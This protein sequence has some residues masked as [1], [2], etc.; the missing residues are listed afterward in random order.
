MR[1]GL[2]PADGAAGPG[3][4]IVLSD[5]PRRDSVLLPVPDLE[6]SPQD[7]E[8]IRWYLEDYR[9]F[10]S[11]PAPV[12]AARC[13]QRL[14]TL[15]EALFQAL[16]D[17]SED[18]RALWRRAGEQ[19]GDLR[20]EV[21]SDLNDVVAVPFELLRIPGG[22]ALS[23]AA[24]SFTHVLPSGQDAR[25]DSTPNHRGAIRIL[26]VICRPFSDRDVPFRSVAH[27]LLRSTERRADVRIQVLRPPTY[28]QLERTLLA[29]RKRG[30]PFH[31]VHFDG[32]G[33]FGA[34][35]A[36]PAQPAQGM[37]LFEDPGS[38]PSVRL[39]SGGQLGALLTRAGVSALVLNACRSDR[40]DPNTP[41]SPAHVAD[42]ESAPRQPPG[43]GSLARNALRSGLGT[44]VAMR[45]NVYVS[46]A[47][48]FVSVLYERLVD[49]AEVAEA[50]T[51]ARRV[52]AASAGPAPR[53][54][55]WLVPVV[56][57]RG[58]FRLF[59]GRGRGAGESRPEP[60]APATHPLDTSLPA[61][62]AT[63]FL[64]GD[65]T[66]IAVDRA[67]D[68]DRSVLLHGE[69]GSGKTATAADFARWYRRT[70]GVLGPVV[71]TSLRTTTCSE[72]AAVRRRLQGL[73]PA[74]HGAKPPASAL[75]IWDD[76]ESADTWSP[77]ERAR[78][79]RLL[80]GLSGEPVR[81]LLTATH[82]MS[83]LPGSL[84]RMAVGALGDAERTELAARLLGPDAPAP[85]EQ[86]MRF[87]Q[88]N[89]MAL[90]ALCRRL[91]DMERADG[92]DAWLET[93]HDGTGWLLGPG[94]EAAGPAT[95]VLRE[96]LDERAQRALSL[97]LFFR[98]TVAA[99]PLS[100]LTRRLRRTEAGRHVPALDQD[101]A[102]RLLAAVA[103]RG[104]LTPTTG[105]HH[106]IHPMLPTALRPL[107]DAWAADLSVTVGTALTE[108][109]DQYGHALF[110]AYNEGHRGILNVIA[111]EE[112]NLLQ[113]RRFALEHA[114]ADE[115][116]GP[117]QALR[118]LYLEKGR[119]QRWC[120]L[121]E[122]LSPTLIEPASGAPRAGLAFRDRSLHAVIAQFLTETGLARPGRSATASQSGR[123][124]DETPAS[125]RTPTEAD[126][127]RDVQRL[128]VENTEPSLQRAVD[129]AHRSGDPTLE[130]TA[131]IRLGQWYRAQR[132]PHFEDM[133][134]SSFDKSADLV[135]E[136]ND[137]LTMARALD[138]LGA[139]HVQRADRL[140]AEHM[141][142]LVEAGAF[143]TSRPGR[144][145]VPIPP[146]VFGDLAAAQDYYSDALARFPDDDGYAHLTASLH[147]QLA[148]VYQRIGVTDE[149]ARHF[150]Q[151][152]RDHERAGDSFRAAQ[153]R[154][155]F[156]NFL[157]HRDGRVED[158][159]LY[160]R[161]ALHDLRLL[162]EPRREEAA[163]AQRLVEELTRI[164]R[165][166]P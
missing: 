39:I 18:A 85:P 140:S 136:T 57:Q 23:L 38:T 54:D 110:Q 126:P 11:D 145:T 103:A 108:I 21:D 86:V 104:W 79:A 10:P 90:R 117:M 7:Q 135:R 157:V 139:L 50:V 109:Y 9:E 137:H 130:A 87:S 1:I 12:I 32:H 55:E 33:M 94:E 47:A 37:A 163:E 22:P 59:D 72:L 20:V 84:E 102:A 75:W 77:D 51:Q 4:E 152:V 148:G 101:S 112:D 45:Y 147:H 97:L 60:P 89:P 122:G 120:S 24:R 42:P 133:A 83:W 165:A 17:H 107:L 138:G 26:L 166:H 131:L 19:V 127:R 160:A 34:L 2:R 119:K 96:I 134:K 146:E 73:T 6:I 52:L 49:G 141:R 162:G 88:G 74:S 68:H 44:V 128:L 30:E 43:F 153:S 116:M 161:Q 143:D 98:T 53:T 106:T 71:F 105:G 124:D 5:G 61:P 80:T 29:A 95:L 41:H 100:D 81:L 125:S 67:F 14:A 82:E 142:R 3:L 78:L 31:I 76:A 40:A 99:L 46:A 91:P 69:V 164:V 113:A 149:A 129:L 36:L 15:G 114:L 62:P 58:P 111:L 144:I 150:R 159:L 93:L 158:A 70:G 154:M 25:G 121:V 66:I 115:V 64:G 56:Y 8:E 16:F 48:T 156:A 92:A 27:R 35:Q 63:G 13:S 155:D 118:M 65:D 28:E 151:A 123:E 132:A